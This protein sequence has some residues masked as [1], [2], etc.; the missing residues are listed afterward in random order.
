LRFSADFFR[1]QLLCGEKEVE[2]IQPAKTPHVMDVQNAFVN[3]TDA[4]YEGLYTYGPDALSPACGTVTLKMFTE[5]E[6]ERAKVKVLDKKTIERVWADF[7][8][9]RDAPSR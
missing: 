1:M 2:P 5:K 6:P 8:A 7:A 9:H 4:S 3:I